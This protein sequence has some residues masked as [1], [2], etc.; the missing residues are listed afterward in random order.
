MQTCTSI[1]DSC[2][3]I[4]SHV[5][6]KFECRSKG[7]WIESVGWGTSKPLVTT[8]YRRRTTLDSTR[9]PQAFLQVMSSQAQDAQAPVLEGETRGPSYGAVIPEAAA[10]RAELPNGVPP[11]VPEEHVR[12]LPGGD[13]D[14]PTE[15]AAA[16][17]APHQVQ[18]TRVETA[19]ESSPLT[20]ERPFLSPELSR[21]GVE[22]ASQGR[23]PGVA[24]PEP[25]VSRDST[26]TLDVEVMYGAGEQGPSVVR[27]VARLTD[28]LRTTATAATGSGGFQERVMEGL[29]LT[30]T[31]GS[32]S[33]QQTLT[34]PQQQHPLQGHPQQQLM[35]APQQ[36]QQV[37]PQGTVTPAVRRN[38]VQALNFSPPE[39][40]PAPPRPPRQDAALFTGEQLQRLRTLELEAPALYGAPADHGSASTASSAVQ[41]EVQRQL[42]DFMNQHRTEATTLRQQVE[43]LNREKHDPQLLAEARLP[44]QLPGGDQRGQQQ[45]P[46]GD[47]RGQQQLPGGDQRGQQQLPGGDQRGQQ[48]LPGGDQRGQQQLPGGD[49]R[50]QQQLPGGD[51]RGFSQQLPG[52]DQRGFSQQLPGG[53]QRGFSQQLPGGDQRGFSQQLPGSDQ[54]GFLQQLPGG[55]QRG[56][57]QQLPGGDQRGFSQQLPGGDQRGFSQQLPGSDQ[58]GFLQQ[59]P[60][61]DQR[62]FSQQLPGGDQRGFSQQLPGGDQRGFSQQLPGGDQR[63][64]SQQLPG[65][66]QPG[67]DQHGFS[68]QLP[69]GD[70]HGSS[71]Q[72]LPGGDQHGSSQQQLP[73]GD[74]HGSSQQQDQG[75]GNSKTDDEAHDSRPGSPQQPTPMELLGVIA[76]GM[77]QLQ[78]VQLKQMEKKDTPEVVKPGI[79]S[80]PM[81]ESPGKET[82]PV[83]I[84]DWLEEVGSIMG[85]LSDTSN[86]W[87]KAV[88]EMADTHYKRWVTAT[89]MEKLALALPKDAKLEYG[90]YGR[91]NSRAAGMIL[92]ALPAEVKSEMV[93]KKCTGSST[94][95][96]FKLL[97]TYRP[98]GEQEKTQLLE[99]LTAPEGATSPDLAVQALRRWG[100]WFSRAQDLAVTV[101]DPVLMV[102]GLASIVNP[103]LSK[104]QDVWLK[105]TMMRNRL[106]LDSNPT[107]ATTLDYHRHL[108]AEMELLSTAS[109]PTGRAPPRLKSATTAAEPPSATPASTKPKFEKKDKP[110]RWFAKSDEGCKKGMDCPFQHDWAGV[111]KAGRCFV[112]SEV[113]HQ[114]KDCPTKKPEF[115]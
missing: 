30:G 96:V 50:G 97:T 105:T 61:G 113:G 35:V 81:L 110:C 60:G 14:Q 8:L 41:A 62:G 43:Q 20:V 89:P 98:G 78:E 18:R 93:T 104:N 16:A 72:Q 7:S 111:S 66:D 49:Q 54:R 56:F 85:D 21:G 79:S 48:Q 75:R 37:S 3:V 53:D 112:C 99:Q 73:G 32:P 27:W 59:L 12:Q 19:A 74:Q 90:K 82:S 71:Q 26:R 34:S 92:G 64:F 88:R 86:E 45:L 80:L 63:G 87:W 44:Q 94:S 13:R 67:G 36:M 29:G 69:G 47:Q 106:Q 15:A 5:A 2:S 108:Q 58:R 1:D 102:K 91:V 114:K 57:S 70:Q 38:V 109:S 42:R 40:L 31:Q 95:L 11:R 107:E 22:L 39:E 84:Q 76:T 17:M 55:D 103:V 68:Q 51:Q 25:E 83:D 10:R 101:P 4:P 9:S 6:E 65:G 23:L 115:S 52:G 46:G 77:R 33:P 28:F 24:N 100:R